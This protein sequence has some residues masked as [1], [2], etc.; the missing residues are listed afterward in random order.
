[1]TRL[2]SHIELMQRP[3][4]AGE[5]TFDEAWQALKSF[6]FNEA[7]LEKFISRLG[8]N[9]PDYFKQLYKGGLE[10]QQV[11]CEI[12]GLIRYLWQHHPA[13]KSYLEI[14]TGNGGTFMLLNE[15]WRARGIKPQLFVADNFSYTPREQQERFEWVR[16]HYDLKAF[17]G[18]TLTPAF[19]DFLGARRFEVIFIDG[20]HHFEG[21]L[22]DFASTY[23]HLEENGSMIFHDITS[24][25]CPGVGE[26]FEIAKKYF[27]TNEVFV[28]SDTCGI[29]VLRGKNRRN[30]PG[31][32]TLAL[33]FKHTLRGLPYRAKARFKNQFNRGV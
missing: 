27:A 31:L 28:D 24:K 3:A 5:I 7:D 25:V 22:K 8:T 23:S 32:T 1:M 21:C 18:D 29:G 14:G 26:V 10:I 19:K 11:P 13:M 20:D 4:L 16:R 17:I 2:D 9:T 15:S 33:N 6:D 12:A 30:I